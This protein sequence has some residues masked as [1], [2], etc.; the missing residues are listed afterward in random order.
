LGVRK[1]QA[2]VLM[3]NSVRRDALVVERG[4]V[5]VLDH[6]PVVRIERLVAEVVEGHLGLQRRSIPWSSSLT[7]FTE[8]VG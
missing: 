8:F 6:D 5:A 2:L 3:A 4:A 1:I 7:M